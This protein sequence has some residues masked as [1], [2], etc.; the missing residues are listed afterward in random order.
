MTFGYVNGTAIED[1]ATLTFTV[2]E[3]S[4][5]TVT[6]V[7][8][9]AAQ[10]DASK[11][12]TLTMPEHDYQVTDSKEPTCTE[13]GYTTYTCVHCGHQKTEEIPAYCPAK[14]FRDLDPAKWYHAGVCYVLRNGLMK[15]MAEGIFAPENALTR[16]QFVTILYRLEGEPNIEGLENPFGDVK[17]D[18]WYTNA[19]VWAASK[20]I[21][22]GKTDTIFDPDA[23]I[24]REQTAA[25]LYR[26]S[27]AKP[28]EEDLLKTYTDA[29]SVSVY[30]IDAMNWAVASGLI[31][32]MTKTTLA[33]KGTATRAQIATILMR[34]G[35]S[36]N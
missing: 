9:N 13:S 36:G 33:P 18:L 19:V 1:I 31:N 7:Q 3:E 5:I 25:I 20:G 34:Y 27:E 6:T 10:P 35:Q 23:A 28:L 32:G 30:A 15:G 21:V 22:I 17:A 26:Y 24:T 16:A 11:Q 14:E 2:K 29:S 12:V 4:A 8:E